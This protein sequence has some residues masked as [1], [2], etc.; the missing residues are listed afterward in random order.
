MTS[1][2]WNIG[3]LLLLFGIFSFGAYWITA[4][5]KGARSLQIDIHNQKILT[6]QARAEILGVAE[7]AASR[8]LTASHRTLQAEID[9]IESELTQLKS[10][11]SQETEG[12]CLIKLPGDRRNDRIARPKKG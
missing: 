9:A 3:A 5:V 8:M 1:Q 4:A 11:L 2:L 6:G 7:S 12:E 10:A